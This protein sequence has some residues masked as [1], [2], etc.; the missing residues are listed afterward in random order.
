[1]NQ[2]PVR[3]KALAARGAALQLQGSTDAQRR[4]ALERFAGALEDRQKE[5]E[6]ANAED[7]RLAEAQV[8][9]GTMSQALLDR[10]KFQ[11][12][13]VR[14]AAQGV[15]ALAGLPDPVG[16]TLR[17][18]LLDDGL[19]L[20][21]VTVPLGV[22]ACAFE[23][24]P[25]AAAQVGALA[26]RS[27]NAVLLKGGSEASRS[28]AAIA[29]L[30]RGALKGAGL[31]EDGVVLLEGRQ[32][33]AHLLEMDDLVDLVIP[34][35]SSGFVKYVQE[36]T[37][38]PVLGHAEGVC[39]T[40][41][42]ERAELDQALQVC[43]DAKLDYPAACNATES[44]L[45][46]RGVAARFVPL[47]VRALREKGVQVFGDAEARRL[48]PAAE[49]A[50]DEHRGR[51]FGDLA[52][53]VWVV[54]SLQEAVDFINRHGSRHTDA[55]LTGDEATARAFVQ[56]V[57]SAGVFVNASTRFADGY[58]YG[59]GAEV[60]VS[61]G[62]VHARGPVGLEGL[63]TTK[64]VLVGGGHT[65]GPYQGAHAKPFKHEPL[66]EAWRG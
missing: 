9:T 63:V 61:T 55:I 4:E 48:A 8:A 64:W 29:A 62:K 22:L 5:L 16:R 33:L 11:G 34:R 13:K 40:Y 31:P 12:S 51:E 15:R 24:R 42:D 41:V 60:G 46:H 57:D 39:H 17:A 66:R 47:L 65:A 7:L 49:P 23:S 44:F 59:L 20:F 53:A 28:N 25:D 32:E 10:L 36:H 26:M 21:Q 54:G 52:C 43:L 56:G 38:I 14:Q 1:M 35:G 18:T 37:R 27:G 50:G 58:R 30:A 3:D 45:V 19:K 2:A 6:A